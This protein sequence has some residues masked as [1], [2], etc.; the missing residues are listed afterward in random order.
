MQKESPMLGGKMDNCGP[1]CPTI[2][3]TR[4]II[5]N[6]QFKKSHHQKVCN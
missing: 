1:S 3:A 5:T 4:T 6:I 2:G